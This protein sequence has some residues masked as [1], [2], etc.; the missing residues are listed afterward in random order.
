MKTTDLKVLALGL[1]LSLLVLNGTQ[2]L[3]YADSGDRTP[4]QIVDPFEEMLP[5]VY[6]A[7]QWWNDSGSW[8]ASEIEPYIGD[9]RF[10]DSGLYMYYYE[11]MDIYGN[12][13]YIEEDYESDWN[14]EWAFSNLLV[15]ILLDPDATYMSWLANN[16]NMTDL[17]ELYWWPETEALSGDEVFIYSSFYF[18][19]YNTTGYFHANYTWY[20]ESWTEVDPNDVLPNIA[21]EYFWAYEFNESYHYDYDWQ[22]TGYGYDVHEM[23]MNMNETLWMD[24]YFDGISVFN[25]TNNNGI[26]DTVYDEIE[27]DWDEDGI[28]DYSYF[29]L[30][31]SASEYLYDFYPWNGEVGEVELPHLNDNNQIEWSAEVVDIQG[32]LWSF[33]PIYIYELYDT[34]PVMEEPVVIPVEVENLIMT[35]RFETSE[36]AAILKIDQHI[37]D[38]TDPETG[39]M[40]EEIQGLSLALNY[41]SSFSSYT[42]DATTWDSNP[43]LPVSSMAEPLPQ[44][45]LQFSDVE[46]LRTMVEFGGTYLWSKDGQTYDVGTATMPNHYCIQPFYDGAMAPTP[47]LEVGNVGNFW[48]WQTFYYS[49]CYGNWDGHA[50]THDPIFSVFP[51]KSPGQV[52]QFITNLLTASVVLGGV[53]IVALGVFCTRYGNMKESA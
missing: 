13:Y 3:V 15:T 51:M 26:M 52:S 34:D 16:D 32:D 7:S 14:D 38:F 39:G 36:D 17:W 12:T 29:V 37:G 42:F 6:V 48:S 41:W 4:A 31:E 47:G 10:N 27:Y 45:T 25:D 19:E 20:D 24:H 40:V 9:M 50:I 46:T 23:F 49:S 53:G 30:N 28:P 33:T 5:G 18:S 35:Y 8:S 22:Y 11:V 2:N 43:V 21:E 44:G 1:F